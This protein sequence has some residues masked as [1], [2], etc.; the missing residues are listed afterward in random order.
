VILREIAMLNV[1]RVSRAAM[2]FVL[3]AA[4]AAVLVLAPIARAATD[5]GT[6]QPAVHDGAVA[7][8]LLA[9]D[10]NRGTIVERIVNEWG[11]ALLASGTGVSREQLTEMLLA[12]RADRLLA[13]SLAGS[14]DGLKKIF[15]GA[16]P[17]GGGR[18][19]IA[20]TGNVGINAL[21]SANSDLVYTPV[22]P[23]RLFDTRAS[24]G[25]A[26]TPSLGVARTV[27]AVTPVVKQ[28]GPGGCS[29]PAGSMVALVLLGTLTPSGP[30]LLQG[31]P[32]GTASFTNAL[33]L[34]QPG[35]QYGTAV[36]VPLNAASGQFDLVEQFATADLYG[37][38]LGY[39]A[40]PVATAIQCVKA[41]GPGTVLAVS[42]DTPVALP[43]CPAGY[44]RTSS[45]CTGGGGNPSVYL[46]EVNDTSCIFRNLS[47]VANYTVS[48]NSTCCQVPGR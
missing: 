32:Q 19:R 15:V 22:T 17:S 40:P 25:G 7:S 24:Q 11:D 26:G 10:L 8:A 27:G 39:F 41:A 20:A 44:A 48:A 4:Y 16:L 5:D 6:L 37:D 45:T 29:A 28:G 3:L 47:A 14:L 9:V 30:G 33:I 31:G 13:A 43:S 18:T 38:L 35:D 21:G 1:A 46:V 34:Y 36:A 2:R 12:M 42:T 23:C